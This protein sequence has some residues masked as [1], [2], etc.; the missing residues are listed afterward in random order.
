MGCHNNTTGVSC[1][2]LTST[3]FDTIFYSMIGLFTV[4]LILSFIAVA[5]LLVIGGLKVLSPRPPPNV[6]PILQLTLYIL[7]SVFFYNGAELLKVM[8]SRD[9]CHQ[10]VA[11]NKAFCQASGFILEYFSLLTYILSFL[12]T[13]Y[14]AAKYV[15]H[16][17]CSMAV[18][19]PTP[20]IILLIGVVSPLVV[21]WI[22]FVHDKYRLAGA[23]CWIDVD[24]D[25]CHLDILGLSEEIAL[26]YL[27][28]FTFSF[29]MFVTAFLIL[30]NLCGCCSCVSN[31][32]KE[33]N[34]QQKQEKKKAQLEFIPILIYPIIFTV[35]F[36]IDV[37]QRI[38]YATSNRGFFS[39]WVVH[40][41]GG[42]TACLLVPAAF[43]AHPLNWSRCYKKLRGKPAAGDVRAGLPPAST[44]FSEGDPLLPSGS[45]HPTAYLVPPSTAGDDPLIIQEQDNTKTS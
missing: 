41:V 36:C 18:R 9:E 40:A 28:V 6:S 16:C 22:P 45:E 12:T 21:A 23:W 20:L 44:N 31:E 24:D 25:H 26:Y 38:H 17:N 2:N 33:I 27:L 37:T 39:L 29:I 32:L 34:A 14:I 35:F 11:V 13:L 3:Q 5:M 42:N 7:V 8:P 30:A 10:V 19:V 43:I 15:L 4:S 1:L